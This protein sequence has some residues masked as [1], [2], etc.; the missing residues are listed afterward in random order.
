MSNF[1]GSVLDLECTAFNIFFDVV[2]EMLPNIVP[3]DKPHAFEI[4]KVYW[5]LIL[6]VFMDGIVDYLKNKKLNN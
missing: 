1:I 2:L 6:N 3:T 5:K 4:E